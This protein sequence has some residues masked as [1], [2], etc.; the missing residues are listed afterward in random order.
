MIGGPVVEISAE[1]SDK[2]ALEGFDDLDGEAGAQVR[3]A[4][5]RLLE[6]R[7]SD[8]SLRIA[9]H[10]PVLQHV[11]LGSKTILVLATLRAA[12]AALGWPALRSDL[13]QLS[14]RGGASGVGIHG[15][16]HGGFIID[17]GHPS[18]AVKDLLPSRARQP[19]TLPALVSRISIPRSWRFH[20]ILPAGRRIAGQNEVDFFRRNTPIPREEALAVA[21]LILHGIAPA[22]A[23]DDLP[24]LTRALWQIQRT[25]FKRREVSGQSA[26]VRGLLADLGHLDIPAGLSSL[27]PLLYAVSHAGD[28]QTARAIAEAAERAEARWLGAWPGRLGGAEVK[29]VD[30]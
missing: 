3:A 14:G 11:G 19:T 2:L 20:L 21:A 15:F 4:L 5:A 22:V 24:L 25:G 1:P 13:Q 23:C 9:L 27:G 30:V 6:A 16:F 8:S 10:S 12:V 7:S 26:D 29:R 17:A 28:S 18:E